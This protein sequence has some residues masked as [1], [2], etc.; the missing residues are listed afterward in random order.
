MHLNQNVVEKLQKSQKRPQLVKT[1][2]I[3]GLMFAG[4][5]PSL[6]DSKLKELDFKTW[7]KRMLAI[8]EEMG[9]IANPFEGK[10]RHQLKSHDFQTSEQVKTRFTKRSRR[11]FD[12]TE[13]HKETLFEQEAQSGALNGMQED[14]VSQKFSMARLQSQFFL[15]TPVFVEAFRDSSLL[16]GVWTSSVS[17][18]DI[19]KRRLGWKVSQAVGF[20]PTLSWVDSRHPSSLVI[21]LISHNMQRSL[22]LKFHLSQLSQDQGWIVGKLAQGLRIV[23]PQH[24]IE[25]VK[26]FQVEGSR[27]KALP[28]AAQG[29]QDCYFLM[30]APTSGL[31]PLEVRF[32]KD[33]KV[34]QVELS[35]LVHGGSVS[36]LDLSFFAVRS[37]TGTVVTENVSS[38]TGR[39]MQRPLD[40]SWVS[41]VGSVSAVDQTSSEGEFFLRE[42]LWVGAHPAF[43]ETHRKGG[44]PHRYRIISQLENQKD[45]QLVRFPV[46]RVKKWLARTDHQSAVSSVIVAPFTQ[47]QQ[48]KFSEK[49]GQG[50]MAMYWDEKARKR[51]EEESHEAGTIHMVVSHDA[52]QNDI[53]VTQETA[54]MVA[55][56]SY[57]Q[58]IGFVGSVERP[59][60]V[61]PVWSEFN[62]ASPGVIT[63]LGSHHAKVLPSNPLLFAPA[64]VFSDQS[65]LDPSEKG[66][67]EPL[68]PSDSKS[69]STK[70]HPLASSVK[71]VAS[72]KKAAN[73][74]TRRLPKAQR[75]QPRIGFEY[76]NSVQSQVLLDL[77][78][79][80][81]E[82]ATQQG[83]AF[84]SSHTFV[85]TLEVLVDLELQSHF[86]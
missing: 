23:F 36:Y 86:V 43:L 55:L 50:Q 84:Q 53:A 45:L 5:L 10:A 83:Q 58:T 69:V 59:Q 63:V 42:C 82:Q 18:E 14:L 73:K 67:V 6:G 62:V 81:L 74:R 20:L 48:K 27:I 71:R 40:Q 24:P 11:A 57:D 17:K 56:T 34:H 75:V 29:E 52:I 47:R 15:D 35:I 85:D 7:N 33:G 1:F 66:D 80:C 78:L 2:F 68:S 9:L 79:E 51:F 77:A 30:Q 31:H 39:V 12:S 8:T 65:P 37:I 32:E 3:L 41:L 44:Y 25:Q 70:G 19:G 76:P 54:A 61:H 16:E 13:K 38:A 64:P 46:K 72:A 21:P 28:E 4:S 49:G 60:A 26:F 22:E